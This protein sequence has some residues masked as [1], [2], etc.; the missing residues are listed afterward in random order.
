MSL[1]SPPVRQLPS[2]RAVT[3]RRGVAAGRMY[4]AIA[5]LVSVVLTVIL[6]RSAR[7]ASVFAAT[8]PLELPIFASLGATG[9]LM[10]FVADRSKGVL[11]YLIS[12]GV[13]PRSLFVNSLIVAAVLST[14]VL[15]CGLAVGLGGYLA[16]GNAIGSDLE[17]AILGYTVP[18][19]YASAL[20]A[21]ISGIVWSTLSTPRAGINSPV[22][23][24]PLLGIAPPVVVL[25][26]A[27]TVAKPDYYYV[28]VGASLGFLALV[29]V[30]LLASARL[31]GRERYL[32]PM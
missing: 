13:E 11:E 26:A 9:A 4:L 15:A 5:I 28:T 18:M 8:F 3:L 21:A 30:L 25:I 27:E 7:G 23:V 29:V 20:F 1:G 2:L 14:L 6:L 32:S 10:L 31:M 19:T 22:G 17:D 24:S 12:Y 16:Q